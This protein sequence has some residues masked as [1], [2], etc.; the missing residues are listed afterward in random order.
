MEVRGTREM[1]EF[2]QWFNVYGK[3]G[4]FHIYESDRVICREA[5]KAGMLEAAEIADGYRGTEAHGGTIA[6]YI[7]GACQDKK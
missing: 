5:F 4:N 1:K 7:R 2:N 3:V 6:E